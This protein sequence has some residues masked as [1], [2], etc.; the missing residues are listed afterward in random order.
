MNS[1][2]YVDPVDVAGDA[3]AQELK[4]RLLEEEGYR[5][6]PYTDTTGNV[7]VGI[8]FNVTDGMSPRV[9]RACMIAELEDAMADLDR[10]APWWR[11]MPLSQRMALLDMAYNLG[12]PALSGFKNMLASARDGDY[13]DAAQHAMASK[14]AAQVGQRSYVIQ[15]L[16][17]SAPTAHAPAAIA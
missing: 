15:Q 3:A 7:T 9:A 8:G 17:L 1:R 14:W 13:A 2:P 4:T 10:N 5:E 11:T 12:W 16:W 6:K